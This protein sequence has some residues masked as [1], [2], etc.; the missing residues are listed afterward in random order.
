M[1]PSLKLVL[2]VVSLLAPGIRVTGGLLHDRGRP[3][4]V[5]QASAAHSKFPLARPV[6]RRRRPAPP[7]RLLGSARPP[8]APRDS[9][10][11]PASLQA[12]KWRLSESFNW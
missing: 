2:R 11:S 12:L 7:T 3:G 6:P 10:E 5:P 8:V 9:S 1:N 4:S